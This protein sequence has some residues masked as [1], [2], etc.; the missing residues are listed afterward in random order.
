MKYF[1]MYITFAFFVKILFI[2]LALI[3]IFLKLKG[4]GSSKLDIKIMYWKERVEFV[5]VTSMSLLIV[6]PAS[7]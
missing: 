3:N 5:F 2:I 7:A 4:K 6:Q 1:D